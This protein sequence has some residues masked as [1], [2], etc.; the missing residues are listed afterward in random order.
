MQGIAPH[1]H[2][3]QVAGRLDTIATRAEA[4]TALDETGHLYDAMG[5]ALQYLADQLMERQRIRDLP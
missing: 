3:Q 4:E 5:P 2:M 1:V